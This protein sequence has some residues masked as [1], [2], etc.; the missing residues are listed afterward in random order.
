MSEPPRNGGGVSDTGAAFLQD[1]ERRQVTVVFCDLVDSS[2]LSVRLDPEDLRDVLRAYQSVCVE[3]VRRHDGFVAQYLGDGLVAY[4]GHPVAREDAAEQAVRAA[5]EMIEAVRAI[6]A[7]GAP[8]NARVGIATGLAVVGD[9]LGAGASRQT[10]ITG[11]VATLA[12]RVQA[13]AGPGEVII[14]DST[15]KLAFS[16]FELEDLGERTL[17]GIDQPVKLWRAG[18]ERQHE[19]RFE[20]ARDGLTAMVGREAE[21]DAL[22]EA[23]RLTTQ[24]KPQAVLVRGEAGIGKSTLISDFLDAIKTDFTVIAMQCSSRHVQSPLHPV[25]TRMQRI[26]GWVEGVSEVEREER[27]AAFVDRRGLPDTAPLLREFVAPPS[28][29]DSA[30]S[31]PVA[32]QR[33]RDTLSALIDLMRRNAQINPVI[34]MIEDIHWA[35]P[36]THEFLGQILSAV[37]HDR[38]MLLASSRPDAARA[39]MRIKPITILDL[40]VVSKKVVHPCPG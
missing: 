36:S 40:D 34:V 21:R 25:I 37:D 6:I 18:G 30:I 29:S 12:A 26:L 10:A 20:A 9:V 14:A 15:R 31:A 39:W 23:W 22:A 8:L 5:R 4:F 11:P 17:K 16:A 13:E 27:L 33:R 24:G 28:A 1:A 35:D 7:D 32:Q 3:A 19:T 2:R 38:V